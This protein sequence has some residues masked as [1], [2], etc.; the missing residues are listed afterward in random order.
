MTGGG[1]LS[2][3]RGGRRRSGAGGG[4][5]GRACRFHA[6]WRQPPRAD[7]APQGRGL[8]NR[9]AA[10]LRLLVGGSA[11]YDAD[12]D[13]AEI[14]VG[15][16]GDGGDAGDTLVL[17]SVAISCSTLAPPSSPA[18]FCWRRIIIEMFGW[19]LMPL[20]FKLLLK[21]HHLGRASG[22][23]MVGDVIPRSFEA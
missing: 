4:N 12:A 13:R 14:I 22:D 5:L 1:L 6:A 15:K 7:H 17:F 23:I 11:G 16:C 21:L 2:E 10:A 18:T 19:K 9:L 3:E 8:L 20:L